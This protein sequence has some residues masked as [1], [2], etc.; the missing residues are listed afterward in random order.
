[1]NKKLLFIT[2]LYAVAAISCKKNKGEEISATVN[3]PNMAEV[4]SPA[5]LFTTAS[6]VNV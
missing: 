2:A 3:Y 6:G 4:N 5:I 1:M